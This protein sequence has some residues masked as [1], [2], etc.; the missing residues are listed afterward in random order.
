MIKLKLI[1]I[2]LLSFSVLLV[3]K[4][5]G[6]DQDTVAIQTILL[7]SRGESLDGQIAVGEV[8]RNRALKRHQDVSAVCM[9]PS[10]F[11]CWNSLEMAIK[12]LKG[13]SGEEYQRASRAW[14]ESGHT[15]LV[16]GADHYC[17]YDC[18]PYWAKGMKP[19]VRISNNV[20]Y[21][22]K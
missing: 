5:Y 4:A 22:E 6:V 14:S 20:F 1:G 8:I 19:I 10:Q 15:N 21:K 18:G 2:L 7:E 17:R 13:V 16:K 3:N 9:A 11:S 12:T